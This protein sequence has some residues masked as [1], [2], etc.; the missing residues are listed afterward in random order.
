MDLAKNGLLIRSLRQS[1]GLTQKQVAEKIGV[2]P[3]T[4]SKWENGKGFPDISTLSILADILGVSERILLAGSL[5]KNKLDSGNMA[6]T[7]FFVCPECGSAV[8]GVGE[9]Q[10]LCCGKVLSPLVPTAIDGDHAISVSEVEDE[11]F[12]EIAHP[13]AKEHFI[14]FIAYLRPDKAFTVRLYPEQDCAVRIPKLYGGKIVYYC[15]KHGLFE[16]NPQK[17]KLK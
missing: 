3:K 17:R 10:I 12:V 9:C 13:M 4:V 1:K 7:K 6:R 15:S 16:F 2:V 14:A 8:Q 11:F 5:V